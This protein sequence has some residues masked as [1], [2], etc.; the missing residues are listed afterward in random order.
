[1][2]VSL[3]NLNYALNMTVKFM[4]RRI[5]VNHTMLYITNMIHIYD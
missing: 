4:R 1:M 2:I 3:A 5:N